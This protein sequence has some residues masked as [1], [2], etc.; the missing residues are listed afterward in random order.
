MDFILGALSKVFETLGLSIDI[1]AWIE[2]EF[3]K[4]AEVQVCYAME[5]RPVQV[6]NCG[7]YG[8]SCGSHTIQSFQIVGQY[9]FNFLFTILK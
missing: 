6:V 4:D 2:L 1:Y 9:L 8:S 7:S 3:L 5:A